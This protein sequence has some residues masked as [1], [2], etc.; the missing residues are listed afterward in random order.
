MQHQIAVSMALSHMLANDQLTTT[1]AI[2]LLK[3][4]IERLESDLPKVS[5]E[6]KIKYVVHYLSEIAKGKDG[7]AGTDDDIISESVMKELQKMTDSSMLTDVL[8]LCMDVVSHK[9]VSHLKLGLC[10]F[11]C[12]NKH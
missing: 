8:H 9:K 12:N 10:C 3:E 4:I 7:I 11:K 5:R 2:V 1:N 6:D